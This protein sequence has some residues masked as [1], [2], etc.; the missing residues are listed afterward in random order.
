MSIILDLNRTVVDQFQNFNKLFEYL[1]TFENLK[2]ASKDP[3]FKQ[4]D[5]SF[6]GF[7]SKEENLPLMEI[8][9][10]DYRF[11]LHG[12]LTPN[13]DMGYWQKKWCMDWCI[14]RNLLVREL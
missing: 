12:A 5:W 9:T 2:S 6:T 1:I 11:P 4:M 14:C 10:G 13:V 8:C 7:S 3:D